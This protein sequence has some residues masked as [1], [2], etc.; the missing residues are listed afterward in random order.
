[1]M[2][3]EHEVIEDNNLEK[4]IRPKLDISIMDPIWFNLFKNHQ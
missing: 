3:K 2:R 1:M 4:S